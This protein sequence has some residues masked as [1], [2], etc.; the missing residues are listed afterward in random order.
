M[1]TVPFWFTDSIS[2]SAN[3]QADLQ[4]I[5]SAG[6]LARLRRVQFVSTGA[7]N[8]VDMR[9]ASGFRFSNASSNDPI[10]NTMLNDAANDLTGI[11]HLVPPLEL[12]GPNQLNLTIID[13]SAAANVVRVTIEGEKDI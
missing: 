11:A 8:L 9:D 2:L 1:A 10:P 6:E 4:L 12:K 7:F 3:A 13:T 5:I